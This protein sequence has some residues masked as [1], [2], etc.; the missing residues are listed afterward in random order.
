MPH[1]PPH[2]LRLRHADGRPTG[3]LA[4][5]HPCWECDKHGGY[6]FGMTVK[7][8]EIAKPGRWYCREHRELG[9]AWWK[10]QTLTNPGERTDANESPDRVR[11]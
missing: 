11:T 8:G 5:V 4:F 10:T 7:R 6:G 1:T 2:R 3:L 9:E